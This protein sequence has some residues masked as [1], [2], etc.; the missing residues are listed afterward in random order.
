M[1]K[2]SNHKVL[3]IKTGY[4]EF[5]FNESESNKVSYGDVLRITP[6]LNVYK[7]DYVVWLTDESAFPLLEKNP[8]IDELLPLNFRTAVDLLEEE[9]DTMINLE[10]NS[11]ICK[12][13]NRINAWR[14]YGFRFDKK[15]KAAQAYDRASEILTYSSDINVK[16]GVNKTVQELLFEMVGEEWKGEEY[17]LGYSP[18][19][20]E[21]YDVGLNTIVGKKW[22]VKS[23]PKDNW[24][25]LEQKLVD[26]G[27]SVSRQ[28][29]Q[30]ESVLT[31]LHSYMDWINSSKVLVT[32]DSLG[33][34]LAIALRKNK[35]GEIQE[36]DTLLRDLHLVH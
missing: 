28:D 33:L 6:I 17:V 30:P 11:D 20:K 32:N 21:V 16:K 29:K 36:N 2:R 35:P 7:N 14:K 22:P 12:F 1:E 34:H 18:K 8:Y 4:S 25:R 9:F 5:L 13:A 15:T 27:F 19:T 26:E 23:W 24:D 10:K 3:I 31:N